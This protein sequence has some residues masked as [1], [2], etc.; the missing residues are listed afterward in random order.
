M[1]KSPH[2]DPEALTMISL[3]FLGR[4]FGRDAPNPIA[5]LYGEIVAAAR[6]P[7]AYTEF[8][9]SDD[10]EGRFEYLTLIATLVLRR[11]R[12]L[13]APAEASAQALVDRLFEGLDDALRRMGVADVS[14]GKK[15]K[16]LAQAFYGRAEA[17]SA[18]LDAADAAA[19]RTALARNLL[20]GRLAPEAVPAGLL[21]HVAALIARLDGADHAALLAGGA[22]TKP[23]AEGRPGP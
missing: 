21:A 15:M 20:A 10:F 11:L 23:V 22:L 9:V 17:Y 14:V 6:D 5:T 13:P 19:L 7:R 2:D 3:P 18:A 8:G 4:L 16:K 1:S 12:A